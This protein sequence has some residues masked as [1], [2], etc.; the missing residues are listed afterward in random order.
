MKSAEDRG[1]SR[2]MLRMPAW[3]TE[4]QRAATPEFLDVCEAYEIAWEAI[5]L[6]GRLRLPGRVEEFRIIA[7]ELEGEALLQAIQ[8]P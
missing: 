1:R 7:G 5:T 8:T 4:L 6:F 2:L 3:R